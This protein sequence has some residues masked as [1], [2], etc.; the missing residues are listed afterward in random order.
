MGWPKRRIA[1]AFL[2]CLLACSHQ[3][4]SAEGEPQNEPR[5][6]ASADDRGPVFDRPGFVPIQQG[7]T[8]HWAFGMKCL[9]EDARLGDVLRIRFYLAHGAEMDVITP[10][11]K[12][13]S[14]AYPRDTNDSIKPPMDGNVIKQV[15]QLGIKIRT[16]KGM[17]GEDNH[18][19]PIFRE[20]GMYRIIVS[21]NMGVD[22]KNPVA[23]A[24]CHFNFSPKS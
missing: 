20:E 7:L 6:A 4:R 9:P 21:S 17:I 14:Y 15:N 8:P 2:T 5:A 22:L 10:S 1:S 11:G 12:W 3:G 16:A 13:F 19:E 23:V 18:L 24:Y